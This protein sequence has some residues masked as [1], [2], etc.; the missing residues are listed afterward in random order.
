MPISGLLKAL[1][2]II[3]FPALACAE[4]SNE[5]YQAGTHYMVLPQQV[6]V[7]DES[8]VEVVEVFWYGCIH[9]YHFDPVIEAWA[10]K[11]AD[12]VDFWRSPAMWNGRMA[13]HAQ[14]FYTAEALGI[15]DEIHTPLFTALNVERKALADAD[16][17]ADFFSKYGVEKE[18][19]HKVFKSF[20]VNS[21]VK[22][23]DA[24]ARSYKIS[25]TPELIVNGKYRVT[26][27][28]AGSQN[29]MLKVVDYLVAKERR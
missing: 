19:F 7:R 11:Q 29:G 12:D 21:Q 27:R 24:R 20:G 2:L 15:L 26:G 13:V 28:S 3:F 25:G 14:A 1:A 4:Q 16:E 22:Q 23:A 9:C 17:L 5:P 8:K 18:D 10:E 6:R